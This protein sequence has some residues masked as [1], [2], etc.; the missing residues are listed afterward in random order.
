MESYDAVVMTM[1]A[2]RVA[3]ANRARVRDELA[4]VQ[5]FAG[6]SGRISFDREGNNRTVVHLV[7][8]TE[9]QK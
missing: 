3:G 9:V 4:R 2:L 1:R 6:V 7:R 5:N 8:M